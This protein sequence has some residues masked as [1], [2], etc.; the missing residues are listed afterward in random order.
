MLELLVLFLRLAE[1]WQGTHRPG[2]SPPVLPSSFTLHYQDSFG[3]GLAVQDFETQSF[4]SEFVAEERTTIDLCKLGTRWEI[5]PDENGQLTCSYYNIS[6]R[7]TAMSIPRSAQLYVWNNEEPRVGTLN[8]STAVWRLETIQ[9]S[10]EQIPQEVTHEYYFDHGEAYAVPILYRGFSRSLMPPGPQQLLY[11]VSVHSF[12]PGAPSAD[13]FVP[14]RNLQC[15]YLTGD[16]CP[17]AGSSVAAA[18][19]FNG[20]FEQRHFL[21]SI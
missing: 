6:C 2:V 7:I 13:N 18:K 16:S 14:D 20:A 5:F 1:A 12:T 15:S 17:M 8:R 11:Q 9:S 21:N 3:E 10:L 4:R 19:A